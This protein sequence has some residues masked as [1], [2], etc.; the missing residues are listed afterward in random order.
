MPGKKP[1]PALERLMSK[2]DMSGDCWLYLGGKKE[3]GYGV[4][5][6]SLPVR[7]QR[8]VH[9]LMFE[10]AHGPVP[11]GHEVAHTCDVRNCVRPSHLVAMTHE[12]NVNDMV[13]K[14]RQQRGTMNPN[15]KLTEDSVREIRRRA[16]GG[17]RRADL[18]AEFGVCIQLI[19]G[20]VKRRRWTHVD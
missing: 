11:E 20:V 14:E 19:D 4:I 18:A 2:L 7:R 6:D 13:T 12:G 17:E 8:Y 3:N 9:R 16:A 5:G 1:T 15:A 10:A